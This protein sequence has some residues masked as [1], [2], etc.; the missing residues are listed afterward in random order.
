VN[1]I[2]QYLFCHKSIPVLGEMHEDHHHSI[3]V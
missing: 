3:F 1:Q 2:H